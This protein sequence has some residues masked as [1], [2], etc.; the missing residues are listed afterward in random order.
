MHSPLALQSAI[1]GHIDLSGDYLLINHPS[2]IYKFY[3]LKQL[4][5]KLKALRKKLANMNLKKTQVS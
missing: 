5:L 1:L 4:L 2:L 3:V